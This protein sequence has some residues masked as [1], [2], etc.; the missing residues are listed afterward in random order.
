MAALH[1]NWAKQTLAQLPPKRKAV[2]KR[3]HLRCY[4]QLLREPTLHALLDQ[5]KISHTDGCHQLFKLYFEVRLGHR[6]ADAIILTGN[7]SLCHCYILEFKTCASP[8]F[9]INCQIRA[10][11]HAEGCSQLRDMLSHLRWHVPAGPESCSISCH[12]V[13]KSQRGLKTLYSK[14]LFGASASIPASR[15]ALHVLLSSLEDRAFKNTL[16]RH[17]ARAKHDR[18]NLLGPKSQKHTAPRPK[19]PKPRKCAGRSAL[20]QTGLRTPNPRK[21]QPPKNRA[22]P[23]RAF[24]AD[25]KQ[26]SRARAGSSQRIPKGHKSRKS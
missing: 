21:K 8:K 2:G 5:L 22:R 10:A 26:R 9:D 18:C 1:K 16:L 17:V 13:F 3:A 7:D 25:T 6:V 12:L 11:Q 14:S 23:R 15:S 20:G 19:H 4:I 24:P